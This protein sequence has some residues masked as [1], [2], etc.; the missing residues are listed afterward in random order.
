ML[1]VIFICGLFVVVEKV[2]S[3]ERGEGFGDRLMRRYIYIFFYFT[4]KCRKGTLINPSNDE[5]RERE[6]SI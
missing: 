2:W 6:E 3:E 4:L 5:G 1:T